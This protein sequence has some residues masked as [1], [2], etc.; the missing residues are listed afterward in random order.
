[1]LEQL[2][3][4]QG[5][6]QGTQ[7]GSSGQKVELL[8]ENKQDNTSS[9]RKRCYN[10]PGAHDSNPKPKHA[11]L[12]ASSNINTQN[13]LLEHSIPDPKSVAKSVPPDGEFRDPDETEDED[14]DEEEHGHDSNISMANP[15]ADTLN[16]EISKQYRQEDREQTLYR[17]FKRAGIAL[18]PLRS[19]N[20][21]PTSPDGKLSVWGKHEDDGDE[22]EEEEEEEVGDITGPRLPRCHWHLLRLPGNQIQGGKEGLPQ[23]VVTSPEGENFGVSDLRWYIDE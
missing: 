11:R 18:S 4:A 15:T 6:K 1:M 14:E 17:L 9:T 2:D 16:R 22:E 21:F 10:S 20:L 13:D 12:E 7:E 23:I 3:Q 8:Y 5:Q 19:S